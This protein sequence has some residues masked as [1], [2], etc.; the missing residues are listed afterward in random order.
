LY[1]FRCWDNNEYHQNV[2]FKREL[3]FAS[4]DQFN[5]PFDS[6]LPYIIDQEDLKDHIIFDKYRNLF[7]TMYPDLSESEI[8]KLAFKEQKENRLNDEDHLK[9]VSDYFR[10]YV[11]RE[12]GVLSMS[13]NE[14]NFLL[15]S[16]YADSHSGY[17]IGFDRDKLYKD[18]PGWLGPIKY[19][20]DF[21]LH[22]LE[23]E[24]GEFL[25]K[26]LLINWLKIFILRKLE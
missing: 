6:S 25:S 22:N 8:H 16:H 21:P 1:K 7:K 17:C 26:L 15:W 20:E 18:L 5:D 2:L 11:K 24:N 12:Y 9:F 14:K 23:E 3:Y 13:K 4:V 19:Q 10:D